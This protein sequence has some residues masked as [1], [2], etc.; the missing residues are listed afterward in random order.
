MR[1]LIPLKKQLK[2]LKLKQT[3]IQIH[4]KK[5]IYNNIRPCKYSFTRLPKL[6][7]GKNTLKF[8]SKKHQNT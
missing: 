1:S 4:L 3:A 6:S 5:Q 2:Q 8:C 7:K